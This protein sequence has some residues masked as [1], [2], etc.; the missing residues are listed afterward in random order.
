MSRA[1]VGTVEVRDGEPVCIR[2]DGSIHAVGG[3]PSTFPFCGGLQA[4]DEG[5]QI[6]NVRGTLQIE[7]DEQRNKRLGWRYEVQMD[8]GQE[9]ENVW[10][11]DGEPLTFDTDWKAQKAL[12]DHLKDGQAAFERGDLSDAPMASEFRVARVGQ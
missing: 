11:E 2:P 6:W 12:D 3:K 9:W 10:S 4:R 5:K 1:L 8:I 7:N